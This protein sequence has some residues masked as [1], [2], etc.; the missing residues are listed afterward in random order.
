MNTT[1]CTLFEG[2]YHHGVGALGNSL[3]AS[4]YRG[5]FWVG[6]RGVLPRWASASAQISP[7]MHRYEVSADFAIVFV[8][9]RTDL[10]FAYYKP[11]FLAEVLDE[12]AKESDAAIYID[13]DIVVKCPWHLLERWP[14]RG[15][16]LVQDVHSA[17]PPGH[18]M[19]MA[20]SEFLESQGFEAVHSRDRYYSAG[21]VGVCRSQRRFLDEWET[22]M[23][24]VLSEI[25]PDKGT[26]HGP[27]GEIFHSTD[28]DALNMALMLD[29]F[30]VNAAGSESMDF[31]SG[32]YMLSH[33][34][35]TPKP[36]NG[37]F[38]FDALRGSPPRMSSKAFLRHS[39]GPI[40]FFEPA[41]RLWLMAT[42]Q[43]SAAI[44]RFYRR[45]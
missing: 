30:P 24:L 38:L 3:S 10:H 8:Q 44:G 35:G 19:R 27:A 29:D 7:D 12:F 33:A 14:R 4:G 41:R 9:V 5:V 18:P 34:I 43:I 6:Y 45:S 42:L 25:G 39:A 20:W 36:W 28:Q 40:E 22:I 32:G 37:G 31:T 21:F 1:V 23:G 11:I 13:P 15:V 16:A 17:M 2:H 26:K